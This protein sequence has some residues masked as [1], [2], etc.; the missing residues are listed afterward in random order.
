VR[1][2]VLA[3]AFTR[4][5]QLIIAQDAPAGKAAP[6]RPEFFSGTVVSCSA[7][8]VVVYRKTLMSDAVT[9][10]FVI[11][12]NTKVEG[13]LKPKA[14]VTVRFAREESVIHAVDIIVR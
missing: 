7:I 10:T 13:V 14:R 3:I 5:A 11:D 8:Q 4:C 6:A 9:K 12:E 2:L 1:A